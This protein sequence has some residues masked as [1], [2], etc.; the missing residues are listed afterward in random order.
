MTAIGAT[1]TASAAPPA[2]H[3]AADRP[4]VLATVG[5][6]TVGWLGHPSTKSW[7]R[8]GMV[9]L[10]MNLLILAVAVV[11]A[12][13]A[14]FLAQQQWPAQSTWAA[15]ALKLFAV[16]CLSFLPGWLY[17]RFLTLRA[18]AIW[19]DY[20]LTLHRLGW[21]LAGNLP[22]P[23][24]TS[25]FHDSWVGVHRGW[26]EP[27]ADENN[28]YRQKFE[29]YYG[30]QVPEAMQATGV[31]TRR[32]GAASTGTR[33]QTDGA[34]N[35]G[36]QNDGAQNDGA[37]NKDDYRVRVESLF[38]VFLATAVIAT[39]WAAVLWDTGFLTAPNG[40]WAVL[41]YAFIG[42]YTF[43]IS[44]LIRRF[45]QTDLRPSAYAAVVFRIILVLITVAVAHQIVQATTAASM[46]AEIALAFVI[47]FFPLAGLKIIERIV[48]KVFRVFLPPLSSD[49]PLDQL[50]GLNLWYEARLT[51]EGVEDMQ[52]LTTMNLVDV[53]LHTRVPPGRLVDWID[54]SL[55]YLHLDSANRRAAKQARKNPQPANAGQVAMDGASV[56]LALR[57]VGIRTATDL[58]KAFSAEPDR[59]GEPGPVDFR[60]PA[61]WQVGGIPEFQLRLLLTVLAND[62]AL[63]P[64]W[65]WQRNGVRV[66]A[67]AVAAKSPNPELPAERAGTA[68]TVQSPAG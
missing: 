48:N 5:R 15:N 2:A 60:S 40:I 11:T 59:I 4:G 64:V 47:G 56:R 22:E 61:G 68:G 19:N 67:I 14:G 54:Q 50:D 63:A 42:A 21:D 53:V 25:E 49:Y 66:H 57:R 46:A 34:Q 52:N 55:L 7:L 44:M 17:I 23:P 30:R 31:R 38:P 32:T 35:D 37:Q 33:V 24:T 58:L 10:L 1:G 29:A 62:P 20:V 8:Q 26:A 41:K 39:G 18:K 6:R 45:F 13:T 28:I 27:G 12:V 3:R 43:V 16:W 65:N 36:A 9:A 51:E